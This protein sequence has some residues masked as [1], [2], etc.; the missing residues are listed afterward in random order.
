ME[1][2]RDL[3]LWKKFSIF[4][5]I[6]ERGDEYKFNNYI[7][8]PSKEGNEFFQY[9]Q[10]KSLGQSVVLI[11]ILDQ[12]GSLKR[13]ITLKLPA[14]RGR[15][16]RYVYFRG[17][18]DEGNIYLNV[19]YESLKKEGGEVIMWKYNREGKLL[20]SIEITAPIEINGRIPSRY[21]RTFVDYR[22]TGEGDIYRMFPFK[23]AV[24]IVK[25]TRSTRRL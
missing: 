23:D 14:T 19:A 10:R 20:A 5:E 18:D 3:H 21:T 25:Y 12:E 24:R 15:G 16:N 6:G 17:L 2:A 9:Q 13:K 11:H 7:G 8:Y 1:G 22:I 4:F